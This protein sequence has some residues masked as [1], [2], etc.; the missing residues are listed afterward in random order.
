MGTV[1]RQNGRATWMIKYWRNGKPIFES[2]GSEDKT[3]ARK[4]LRARE[5]D[6]DK[7]LP[8]SAK[9]G[10]L[11]FE[12]AAADIIV[13]YVIK[14]RKTLGHLKTRLTNHLTPFFGAKRRMSEIT[15]AEVNAFIQARLARRCSTCE[16]TSLGMD[17]GAGVIVCPACSATVNNGAAPA[18]I[19]RELAVLKRMYMVA[20][21][22]GKLLYRPYFDLLPEDNVRT[23]FFEREQFEAVFV[24]LP[25]YLQPP[26]IFEYLTGWRGPSEVFTRQWRHVDVKACTMRL[27]PSETK[28]KEGRLFPY[29]MLPELRAVIEAQHAARVDLCPYVF[30]EHGAK[31][32]LHRFYVAWR[33]A[34][35]AAGWPSMIQHD[36]RRTAVRNLV[37]AGVSEKIAM[38]LTGH[39]T[40]AVFDRY[41]IVTEA[42][43]RRAV[44]Q[45]AEAS[46][47]S[48]PPT[49]GRVLHASRRE[50]R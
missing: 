46:T 16:W 34:C 29:G 19:N 44:T 45:L 43:L 2:S 33:A 1:F 21:R 7:G 18:E 20:I 31:I 28:T 42:D 8:V 17:D 27:E 30:H 36:F 11:R 14:G 47:P 49:R 26:M 38:K 24:H 5:T 3:E 9:V 48:A 10:K 35:Q 23:G 32:Q 50:R 41:H 39:K 13:D 6:I 15:T 12:E 4:V 37:R 40:R 22:G 25:A